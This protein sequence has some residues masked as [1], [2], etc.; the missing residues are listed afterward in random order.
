MGQLVM[1]RPQ[2]IASAKALLEA[3]ALPTAAFADTPSRRDVS[4][5]DISE[6]VFSAPPHANSVAVR[7]VGACTLDGH[8]LS[9]PGAS[10]L[11][12]TDQ[13]AAQV[14]CER[15]LW[16]E[17]LDPFRQLHQYPWIDWG[18]RAVLVIFRGDNRFNPGVAKSVLAHR[19]EPVW[20]FVDFDPSGLLI[21]SAIDAQRLARLVLPDAHWL[22][23]ACNTSYGREQFERQVGTCQKALDACMHP[24]ISSHWNLMQSLRS[25]VTQEKMATYV[26][27]QGAPSLP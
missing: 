1:Y 26:Q 17:N 24:A 16:V 18:G 11:V 15:L 14:R 20:A 5:Y 22:A 21:A 7:V 27:G 4:R 23:Q 25:A 13:A 8:R 9:T 19:S 12:L 2:H 6:K 10:Y 3:H